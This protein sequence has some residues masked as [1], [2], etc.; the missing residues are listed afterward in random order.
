MTRPSK[1]TIDVLGHPTRLR[2][3]GAGEP[4][5]L[6]GGPWLAARWSPFHASLADRFDL[7]APDPPGFGETPL[8]DTVTGMTDLAIHY[9]ALLDA[10]GLSRV[11]LVGH[12]FG[13][14]VAAEFAA[15]YPE[16]LSSLSLLAPWGLR[17]DPDEPLVNLFRTTDDEELALS[18][19]DDAPRWRDELVD[20]DESAQ[21]LRSFQERT[22]IARVAWNPRYDLKLEHRLQRVAAPALILVPQ[23][24]DV[25]AAS[26][27]RQ[28]RELLPNCR[29]TT[30]VGADHGT[31]HL[32]PLQQPEATAALIKELTLAS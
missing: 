18:L 32:F 28:Y 21:M 24:D 7:L 4:L 26:V 29:L 20:A 11:H 23:H 17:P 6:I 15:V 12:G 8:P 25:V 19:G 31:G 9:R 13:G 3:N 16:C 1:A 2:R 22:A 10:L 30:V 14:W 27:P 5:V